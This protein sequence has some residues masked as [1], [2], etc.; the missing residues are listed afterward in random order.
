MSSKPGYHER[1]A[2]L[3]SN[4]CGLFYDL[5]SSTYNEVAPKIEYWIEYVLNGEFTTTNELAEQVS[6]LAWEVRGSHPAISLFL[7]AFRDAPHRSEQ[8]RSFVDRLCLYLLRW[9]AVASAED[10]WENWRSGS[11]SKSGGPGFIRAASFLG[12]L[13]GSGLLDRELVRQHI[14]KPLMNHYYNRD[15]LRKQSIRANAIYRLF[16]AARYT[17]LQGFL[18]PEEVQDCFK[19]LEIRVELG[20]IKEMDTLDATR[21][22][23]R[24]DYCFGA[25]I[26][27]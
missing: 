13:I 21:L 3:V 20:D 7:K 12:Y 4:I 23:V 14:F 11:V 5:N 25:P 27:T 22:T 10:L 17:L 1:Q 18:E 19:I 8:A 6:T 24:C 26:G 15:N 16:T 9:F 2:V